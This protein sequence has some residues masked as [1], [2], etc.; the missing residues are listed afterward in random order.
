[1]FAYRNKPLAG[2]SCADR[3]GRMA[4]EWEKVRNIQSREPGGREKARC[5]AKGWEP[6]G[7]GIV[8]VGKWG[9]E[10]GANEIVRVR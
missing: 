10:A 7:S 2:E 6:E 4:G 5:W 3:W 8:W 1:M 9:W